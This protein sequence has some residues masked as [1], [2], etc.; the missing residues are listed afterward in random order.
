[1]SDEE[2][3]WLVRHKVR[4]RIVEAVGQAGRIS[5]TSLKER[6]GISTGS[7]YYNLRQM[8]ALIQQDEKRSYMLTEGGNR[9]YKIVSGQAPDSSATSQPPSRLA[10]LLGNLFFPVWLFSPLYEARAAAAIVS[11][12]SLALLTFILI[13]ARYDMVLLHTSH[14]PNFTLSTFGMKML[15]TIG[16]SYLYLSGATWVLAGKRW[17]PRGGVSV[18]PNLGTRLSD[19]AK[20]LA[21]L[22]TSML[23]MA[24]LPSMSILDRVFNLGLGLMENGNLLLRDTLL[25]VSQTLTVVLLTAA[26]A[27]VKKFSWQ[28]SLAAAFSYFYLSYGLSYFMR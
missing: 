6:L 4:R 20:F 17:R 11:P 14:T 25:V 26:T 5:A 19:H 10:G 21:L 13:N 22:V 27:Y 16:V 23:P 24:L 3:L 28:T 12:L 18:K 9:I 2:L 8:T 7:L 15:F 1:L